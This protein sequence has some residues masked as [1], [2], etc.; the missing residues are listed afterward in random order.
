MTFVVEPLVELELIKS[1]Q[2]NRSQ[3]NAQEIDSQENENQENDTQE[4]RRQ[5]NP[6][7]TTSEISKPE[8]RIPEVNMKERL[9]NAKET[10]NV[11]HKYEQKLAAKLLEA[12]AFATVWQKSGKELKAKLDSLQPLMEIDPIF[13]QKLMTVLEITERNLQ[14]G[15]RAGVAL[16]TVSRCTEQS[17]SLI[18]QTKIALDEMIDFLTLVTGLETSGPGTQGLETVVERIPQVSEEKPCSALLFSS[19][20]KIALAT[21][22][23]LREELNTLEDQEKIRSKTKKT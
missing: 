2:D 11:Y 14:F 20:A 15:E 8:I 17:G 4:N 1:T 16:K 19:P 18:K 22:N 7:I 9:G 6:T 23:A 12:E 3:E 13:K 5:E 21:L 10:A